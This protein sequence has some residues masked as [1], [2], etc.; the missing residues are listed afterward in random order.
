MNVNRTGR[1]HFLSCNVVNNVEEV[2][3]DICG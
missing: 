1:T 3:D 2:A